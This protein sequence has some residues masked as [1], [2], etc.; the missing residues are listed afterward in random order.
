MQE[1]LDAGD[2]VE[3][4]VTL[5]LDFGHNVCKCKKTVNAAR[6]QVLGDYGRLEQ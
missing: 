1:K 2:I 6:L 5:R 4:K 3:I